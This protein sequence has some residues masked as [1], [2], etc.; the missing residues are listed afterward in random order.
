SPAIGRGFSAEE[1]V[2]P[3]VSVVILSDALWR[4]RF[5]ADAAVIGRTIQLNGNPLTVIGVMP[6]DVRLQMRSNSLVGKP[7]DLWAPW[8]L[9]AN[10]R[11]ARGRYMSV[12]AR[13]KPTVSAERARV[14][15]ATIG[16]SLVTELPEIDTGWSVR[17][18]S[19]REELSGEIR[20]A[21]LMLAG[22][23]AFVLLIACANVA[24]LL[25]ARGAARQR[26][27][28]I[29]VALGAK[30]SR[31]IRQLL[32]ETL[33]L[34]VMGGAVGLLVAVWGLD[35]MLAVSPVDVTL[36]G[37]VHLNRTVLAFTASISF[38]TTVMCGFAPAFESARGD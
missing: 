30:R 25:L 29:R 27:I 1:S 38:L 12:V 28:A 31:L 37:P 11:D 10:A 33:L 3:N 21:L 23:V 36:L 17:V 13:L 14:E 18:L 32:T 9:P 5:G 19:L 20:P 7:I 15:M 4:R 34:A 24:N 6:P 8:V 2:D 22:A 26:E 35:A 16:A